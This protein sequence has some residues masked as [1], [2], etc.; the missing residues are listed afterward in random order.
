M[1]RYLVQFMKVVLGENGREAE[2]CQRTMEV[3][4]ADK[5]KAADLAKVNFCE[6]ECVKDWSLHA[7]SV[8]ITDAEFRS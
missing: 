5:L 4:A 2:I 8:R 1:S 6:N 7:D 3:D